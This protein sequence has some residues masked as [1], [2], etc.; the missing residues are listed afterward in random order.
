MD[1]TFSSTTCTSSSSDRNNVIDHNNECMDQAG[2]TNTGIISNEISNNVYRE[3]CGFQNPNLIDNSDKVFEPYIGVDN[4]NDKSEIENTDNCYQYGQSGESNSK[5]HFVRIKGEPTIC[6]KS[7]NH[8]TRMET[9]FI[10]SPRSIQ[11]AEVSIKMEP[12]AC[13]PFDPSCCMLNDEMTYKSGKNSLYLH[14]QLDSLSSNSTNY[15]IC[16]KYEPDSGAE[17]GS[18]TSSS[19]ASQSRLEVNDHQ[20]RDNRHFYDNSNNS[21]NVLNRVHQQSCEPIKVEISHIAPTS[22]L[23]NSGSDKIVEPFYHDDSYEQLHS[24]H[25]NVN[26]QEGKQ[27]SEKP[28]TSTQKYREKKYKCDV[29]SHST[30]SPSLLKRHKMQHTGERPYKCDMCSYSTTTM[31][32]LKRHKMQHTGE[33]PYKCDMCSYSTTRSTYLAEHKA[34]H[35]GEKPYKCDVCSYSTTMKT[36]LKRHKMQHTGEKPYKC[37]VCSYMTTRSSLFSGTSG[38]AYRREIIQV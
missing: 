11:T 13:D 29:C 14:E 5:T 8:V 21:D 18:L 28:F 17:G 10:E 16:I 9:E 33:K 20:I 38:K 36:Y 15:V 30:I 26:I 2:C 24:L 1:T 7:I 6:M 34:R 31:S 22:T 19:I 4:D 37:D 35:T 23:N 12:I 25:K 32:Y 3:F 27:P